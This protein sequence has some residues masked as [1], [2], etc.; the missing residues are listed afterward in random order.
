MGH[1]T[2]NAIKQISEAFGRRLQD[3]G[4]TR[5]QWIALYY[6]KAKG[7]ISQRD[8]SNLMN[9]KDSSAGRLI[10]RLERDGLIERERNDF[11]RRVIYIKLTDKGDQL[12]SDLMPI[13]LH[14]NDDL[15]K[16][17]DEQEL[18]IYEKI[19]NKMLSNVIE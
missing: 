2:E 12:I 1:I 11:D 3:T 7:R 18:I 17:I 16:G 13:G 19:L 15:L 6:V 4:I 5:V 14:F 10:D 8:L 9:V